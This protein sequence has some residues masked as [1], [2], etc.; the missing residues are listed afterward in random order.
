MTKGGKKQIIPDSLQL[1]KELLEI[2]DSG[3][4][5][6]SARREVVADLVAQEFKR[7][8][9]VR[10]VTR[11]FGCSPKTVDRDLDWVRGEQQKLAAQETVAQLRAQAKARTKLIV[12]KAFLKS[13]LSTALGAG[14]HLD[15]LDGLTRNEDAPDP[16]KLGV[17]VIPAKMDKAQ[18]LLM[19]KPQKKK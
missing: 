12:Q 14:K 3:G 4:K 1:V 8:T 16:T 2:V 19:P 10:V 5:T 15:T 7:G 6:E 18:W 13:D 17:V 9:I 11:L